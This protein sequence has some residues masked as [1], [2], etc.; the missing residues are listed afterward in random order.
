MQKLLLLQTPRAGRAVHSYTTNLTDLNPTSNRWSIPC[1]IGMHPRAMGE[2]GRLGSIRRGF[3][4]IGVGLAISGRYARGPAGHTYE[5][6][7]ISGI[8]LRSMYL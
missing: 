8:L 4:K 5:N 3:I 7:E 6:P 1:R 2:L